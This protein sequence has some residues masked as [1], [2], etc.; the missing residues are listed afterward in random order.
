[1]TM[2]DSW[3][4]VP[5]DHYK[6]TTQLIH[7]LADVV[8]KGGNLLLNV[9]PD[10]DG[11]LP[12]EAVTRMKE[13]GAWLRV[14]GEAIY[15]TQPLSPY[16]GGK[17]GRVCYTQSKDGK[18]KYAIVLL[19][20]PAGIAEVYLPAKVKDVRMLGAGDDVI[21]RMQWQEGR[22]HVTIESTRV[23]RHAIVLE[24]YL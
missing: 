21:K 6:S 12:A 2:G 23:M 14:N 17:S 3:S 15:G 24:L 22:T 11:N 18:H 13:I 1:M 5:G 16:G 20:R 7:L 9:G 8:S 10:A 19:P 4:Y